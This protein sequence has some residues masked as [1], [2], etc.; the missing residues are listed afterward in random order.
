VVTRLRPDATRDPTG[1]AIYLRDVRSGVVWSATHQPTQR[2][3]EDYLVHFL[4][5]K[6]VFRRR[7]DGIDTQLEVAVSPEDD[8]EVRRL[9]LS[10]RDDR[11]REIEI[12]SY[13]EIVLGDRA[14][15]LAHPAFGKLFVETEYLPEHTALLCRRRPRASSEPVLIAIHTLSVEG[16]LRGPVEWETD[17]AAFL[18]HGR[19]PNDPQALDGRPLSGSVGAV[20]DPIA[21]LRYRVRLAPGGFAR[22][23]FATGVAVGDPAALALAQKYHDE[24]MARRAVT[25]ALTHVQISLRHL[26]LG[27]DEAQLFERLASR[28]FWV[29]PTLR[30]PAAVRA[31]NTR[32]QSGLWQFGISGDVP[33]VVVLVV[34]SDDQPL[35]QQV[36]RREY[37]SGRRLVI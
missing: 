25:L 24:G 1:H 18:G 4:P 10:N 17:R 26:G 14:T 8:V 11:E 15:D 35:V 29:D 37:P 34:E 21:A 20:L 2:D 12:T 13:A 3:P 31:D 32:G 7:D 22:L 19:E 23:S 33:I 27:S 5:E 28:V 36:C 9:S 16:G 30:A 6:A